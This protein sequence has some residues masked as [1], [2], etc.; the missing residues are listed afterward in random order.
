M[1]RPNAD[2]RLLPATAAARLLFAT[3]S[4]GLRM[5]FPSVAGGSA[6]AAHRHQSEV[7]RAARQAVARCPVTRSHKRSRSVPVYRAL[8]P[9]I[10]CVRN[11]TTAADTQSPDTKHYFAYTTKIGTPH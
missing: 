2:P 11:A 1:D 5:S 9:E 10:H 7:K 8:L 6:V 4:Q 3:G